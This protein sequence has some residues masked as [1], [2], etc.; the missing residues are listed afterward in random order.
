M[1]SKAQDPVCGMKVKKEDAAATSQYRGVTYFFCS[2]Q[3]KET[4]DADPEAFVS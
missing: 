1:K 3:C 2:P 4:F